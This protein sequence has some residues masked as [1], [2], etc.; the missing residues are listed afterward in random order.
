MK[1]QVSLC[2]CKH[3][4]PNM[5][6]TGIRFITGILTSM[7]TQLVSKS[8]CIRLSTQNCFQSAISQIRSAFSL[9]QCLID[10]SLSTFLLLQSRFFGVGSLWA[11][12]ERGTWPYDKINKQTKKTPLTL[13][14]QGGRW[15]GRL[16][17]SIFWPTALGLTC[18][19][20]QEDIF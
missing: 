3:Y 8:Q 1:N 15:V 14:G 12:T 11:D 17:S 19:H 7:Q 5:I 4:I 13:P 10:E 16:E 2:A 18:F 20:G 6:K 9:R